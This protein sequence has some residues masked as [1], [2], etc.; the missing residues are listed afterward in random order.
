MRKVLWIST[1]TSSRSQ[2]DQ[3]ELSL[4]WGQTGVIGRVGLKLNNF[5]MANLFRRN[6]E[7]RGILPI[8]DGETLSLGAQT[9]GTYYQSY[10]AQYQP[11]GW[12]VSVLSSSAWVCRIQSR[13]TYQATTITVV[14]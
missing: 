2:N 12:E 10:N 11:T 9:N 3:V 14:T 5:S 7:H 13:L 4:G 6:R 8:G 1:I